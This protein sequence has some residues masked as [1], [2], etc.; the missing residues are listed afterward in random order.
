MRHTC[1]QGH[2]W[3]LPQDPTAA[4]DT[5]SVCPVC[6]S[7]GVPATT[8][9]GIAPAGSFHHRETVGP[10]GPAPAEIPLSQR[11]TLTRADG[12]TDQPPPTATG[13]GVTPANRSTAHAEAGARPSV[14]GY[15]VLG[16][17]GRGGMGVVYKARQICLGR[18][19][20][21]KMLLAGSH[22]GE[23]DL[24]R[25]RAEAEA[26]A[27]LQH[28]NIVQIYE[29]GEWRP[30]RA[31][32]PLPYF[33]MEHVAGGSLDRRTAGTPQPAREAAALVETL[34][35][36]MHA[37]HQAGVVHRDLKPAN[38]LLR[39]KSESKSEI[40]NPKSETNSNPEIQN[41][42]P[43][44]QAPKPGGRGS[45]LAIG[46]SDFGIV[47]DFGFRIS[48]FD[49]KIT[50]FGLAKRLDTAGGQ[51]QSGAIMGTPSYM[52][53]EQAQGK[54]K[55]IGPAADVYALGAILYELLTG[56]PPFRA[57]TAVD[58]LV[59]V[60]TV[61]PVPPRRLQPKV[62]RDL[63][64]IC[65]KCVQKEPKK[66]Y[67]S[68]EEL[69]ED[70]R[71]FQANEPIRARPAGLW[72]RA[73]KWARRR[74]A[75]AASLALC[76]LAL[77]ALVGVVLL[78]NARLQEERNYALREEAESRRRLVRFQ[79]LSGVHHLGE[80][81]T[82][83]ALPW[84]AE[85]LRL[86][87]PGPGPEAVHRLRLAAVLRSCPFPARL[88]AHDK[89]ATHAEFSPDGRRVLV[90]SGARVW[91]WDVAT[92]KA[93]TEP[94]A[95]GGDVTHAAFSPDGKRVATAGQDGT[96]R[97]WDAATGKLLAG[98]LKHSWVVWHVAFQPGGRLLLT[99]SGDATARVWDLSSTPP[100]FRAIQHDKGVR[101]AAFSPDGKRVV[102]ASTDHTARV[103]ESATGKPVGAPLKHD[104][105][106]W[107][108]A[109]SPDG[110]RVATASED[111]TA[112]VW[113]AATG[114]PVSGSLKH[115]D[116]VRWVEFSPDGKRVV[117]A[118]DDRR[119]VVWDAEGGRALLPPLEHGHYLHRAVFSADGRRLVTASEDQTAR[120]WDAATGLP[121]GPPLRHGH[122]VSHAAFDQ[123][124]RRLLTAC[125][126]GTV[127]V[128]DL[129]RTLAP[130]HV[131][132]HDE[133]V[134]CTFFSPDGRR[135]VTASDDDT[136]R[137][138]DAATGAPVTP[139][140]K[141]DDWVLGAAFSPDG[142]RVATASRDGTARVWDAATGRPVTGPLKH[143]SWVLRVS[144]SPDGRRVVT[145]S[146]DGSARLW[147]ADTGKE[148]V[149]AL[150]HVRVGESA[151]ARAPREGP[152]VARQEQ[153]DGF[154]VVLAQGPA[155]RPAPKTDAP[156]LLA[157]RIVRPPPTYRPFDTE[158]FL[159]ARPDYLGLT[160]GWAPAGFPAAV[161]WPALALS[162]GKELPSALRR[163]GFRL[164]RFEMPRYRPGGMFE[165][166]GPPS[167]RPFADGDS[168]TL[169]FGERP[170]ALD[171]LLPSPDGTV[172]GAVYVGLRC[173]SFS[174]DGRRVVTA[175]D[176]R[177][178]CLWDAGTGKLLRRLPHDRIVFD[179][180]FS[181]DG[182]RLVTASGDQGRVWDARTGEPAG[183]PLKHGGSV[184]QA[185]FSPDGTQV[186]T[187][188]ADQTARVW[189]AETGRP[190]TPPLKH[191]RMVH[192]ASFS[193]DGGLVVTAGTYQA[194]VW[195]AATG[196]PITPPLRHDREVH[197]AV[198]SP[199]GRRVLTASKDHTA[200]LWELP[201]AD[202]RP[203]EDLLL[204]IELL[205]GGRLDASGGFV[206]AD[207]E[208]L[209]KVFEELRAK[210]PKDFALPE[211][212]GSG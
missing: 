51:T 185:T 184:Y 64:T 124:A 82:F 26:V 165:L 113:D 58:T 11:D 143:Q 173:A 22:A 81:D 108:A 79:V 147:D 123:A 107:H 152:P 132:K 17:L 68:A 161:P 189:D 87:R 209:K 177:T 57:E 50:D 144:F 181:P 19:V 18:V 88:W 45:A 175:G 160:T 137:V 29:V 164:P 139:P 105:E 32:D 200:R 75:V 77:A 146:R 100:T 42:K 172:P 31:G 99:A 134:N 174:P 59:Q 61:E 125:G 116:G 34:A 27:R 93:V 154:P 191:T 187:A 44:T 103:W 159:L 76:A 89:P 193:P 6:S 104:K 126:D 195:N 118:S 120:V 21:L 12:T 133:E 162:A 197:Q 127:R 135:V 84:F 114:E 207:G 53:P 155:P 49:P 3:E 111:R 101:Y 95:H 102:T 194:W 14:A 55:E 98:P 80:G 205:V 122:A 91:L 192:Q 60:V 212:Q 176:D 204:L 2:Q 201:A 38:V 119:A 48:D 203:R 142:K 46:D 74:P 20:A 188:S 54:S 182:R 136:A 62:P 35:R 41:P 186:V 156:V 202:D 78:S 1:P 112:R 25:F 39:R 97:V 210:Y 206:P 33:S 151:G 47:S 158:P 110:K 170:W 138:W 43:E 85:A 67:G 86:D 183:P 23:R 180:S 179:A 157:Q 28:P 166:Y 150:S 115:A 40:R 83:A 121:V 65:L 36:A 149:P 69:A 148:L 24:L 153:A 171:P 13:E 190:L 94:L 140:L 72:E 7:A 90:A 16:E 211:N 128:W 92:G 129:S 178:A 208:S 141:H 163:V 109:F 4:T 106:V 198:F 70:L 96:A 66:R 130:A 131:F 167:L 9:D 56:R 30:E 71:R 5:A 15:E 63:E 117:T 169:L 10:A 196:E 73:V 37:A 168:N 52:A 145:A 199:D 8:P